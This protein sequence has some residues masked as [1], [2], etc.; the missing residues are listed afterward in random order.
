M[1]KEEF[2]QKYPRLSS[3]HFD[4]KKFRKSLKKKFESHVTMTRLRI[5]NKNGDFQK[6]SKIIIELVEQIMS[7]EKTFSHGN[8]YFV[9]TL[10][11][12]HLDYL[13]STRDRVHGSAISKETLEKVHDEILT[14][15]KSIKDTLFDNVTNP[16]GYD[17]LAET[18]GITM[19]SSE[20]ESGE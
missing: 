17:N 4:V 12:D 5:T 15:H 14:K 8:I 1:K 19:E 20:E 7:V 16:V 9:L 18:L 13:K 10:L 6:D 3:R 11:S 2:Y